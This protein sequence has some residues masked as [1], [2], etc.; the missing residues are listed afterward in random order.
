MPEVINSPEC[1]VK[2]T[3]DQL[4]AWGF[5]CTK[6]AEFIVKKT[7]SPEYAIMC[8]EHK[9]KFAAHFP[10]EA[11]EYLPWTLERNQK[12]AAEAEDYWRNTNA[13]I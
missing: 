8:G 1:K 3:C 11:V 6:P 7:H 9:K 4:V 10:N 2:E 12:L 5:C 13:Q